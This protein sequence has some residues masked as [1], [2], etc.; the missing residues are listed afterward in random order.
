M[1]CVYVYIYSVCFIFTIMRFLKR[2]YF[3][4]EEIRMCYWVCVRV[5]RNLFFIGGG[6]VC[7]NKLLF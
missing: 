6:L 4:E 7:M 1:K 3:V 5:L 2:R